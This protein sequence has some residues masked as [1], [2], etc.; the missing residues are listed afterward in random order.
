MR[1]R[2]GSAPDPAEETDSCTRDPVGGFGEEKEENDM[3]EKEM[4]KIGK[5]INGKGRWLKSV[6]KTNFWLRPCLYV[7]WT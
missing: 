6:P 1:L 7:R 2:P 3:K 5:E 4:K